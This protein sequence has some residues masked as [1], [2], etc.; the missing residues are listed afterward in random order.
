MVAHI[1]QTFADAYASARPSEANAG[2]VGVPT[3]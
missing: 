2:P 1:M 3:I